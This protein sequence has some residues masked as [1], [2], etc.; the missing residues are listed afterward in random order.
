MRH[1]IGCPLTALFRAVKPLAIQGAR[2]LG[3]EAL[4]T[5]AQIL[6]DIG[7]KQPERKDILTDRLAEST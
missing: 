1:G 3:R 2:D 7:N 4:N 6:A 5:G